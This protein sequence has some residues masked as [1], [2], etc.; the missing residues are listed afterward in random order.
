MPPTSIDGRLS[1]RQTATTTRPSRGP[2]SK[3]RR[4][5][6]RRCTRSSPPSTSSSSRH[7]TARGRVLREQPRTP[8]C[9]RRRPARRRTARPQP[10][11]RQRPSAPE[12]VSSPSSR[13]T[14]S[15]MARGCSGGTSS[16]VTP[17][18][19]TSATAATR[20]ATTGTPQDC[21]SIAVVVVP[22]E[23]GR[24]LI[25]WTSKAG[26][27]RSTSARSPAKTTGFGSASSVRP[28]AQPLPVRVM[29]LRSAADDHEPR[30]GS[31][32]GDL[33]R[34]VDEVL[35]P[36]H[37]V[38]GSRPCPR[39]ARPRESRVRSRTSRRCSGEGTKRSVSTGGK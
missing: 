34:R 32:G 1:S 37:R 8:A 31:R 27:Q 30:L 13:R 33:R 18:S 15:A 22:S 21:A 23:R 4:H 11:G 25:T 39:P 12:R 3:R 5:A 17:S 20:V 19:T 26:Y 35:E 10:P 2:G 38:R 14:A 6:E 28:A 7:L 24:E 29:R 9:R 36:L 16:P